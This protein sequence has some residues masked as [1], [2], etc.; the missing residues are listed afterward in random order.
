M[1]ALEKAKQ[2]AQ[3]AGKG[4][5]T[6]Q[7]GLP[8]AQQVGQVANRGLNMVA[9]GAGKAFNAA[10]SAVNPGRTPNPR[11]GNLARGV[12]QTAINSATGIE[13][14]NAQSGVQD[15]WY[16]FSRS[17][18][19][20][21]G[22]QIIDLGS[23]NFGFFEA[24]PDNFPQTP[25]LEPHFPSRILSTKEVKMLKGMKKE[26]SETPKQFLK[27]R[28]ARAEAFKKKELARREQVKKITNKIKDDP[29]LLKSGAIRPFVQRN[30]QYFPGFAEYTI[31][32]KS[33]I[34]SQQAK[35]F[36][37]E[38][39]GAWNTAAPDGTFLDGVQDGFTDVLDGVGNA[40]DAVNPF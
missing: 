12:A 7:E 32:A 1:N 17:F 34:L 6:I 22:S 10:Q 40:I 37:P 39:E 23:N 14:A 21:S 15:K 18:Y 20:P 11:V 33:G 13:D 31:E 9:S 8:S 30:I 26:K 24:L 27:R 28:N 2:L 3:Q 19:G 29:S 25:E 4:M 5:Q 16:D 35:G 38:D 36:E